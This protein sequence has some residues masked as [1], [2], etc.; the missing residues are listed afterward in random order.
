MSSGRRKKGRA[1]WALLL[2]AALACG[3]PGQAQAQ[4]QGGRRMAPPDASTC[5]RDLL[6]VYSGVVLS[7]RRVP[8][9]TTLRIRTDEATTETV[10][11]KT[12]GSDDP[13]AHFLIERAPFTKADWARIES[14]PG[15]LRPGTRAAAWV[16][17]DGSPPL[18]DWLPPREG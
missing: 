16:C 13:S 17:S 6:T 12:P 10:R 8:G 5:P 7:Y 15:R 14:A 4:A 18:I 9:A 2:G 11:V 3:L 1:A